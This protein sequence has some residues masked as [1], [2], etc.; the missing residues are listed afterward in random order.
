MEI[1]HWVICFVLDCALHFTQNR[2]FLH[3]N[4][5]STQGTTGSS[6]FCPG[7]AGCA[8]F[9]DGVAKPLRRAVPSARIQA[10]ILFMTDHST[11]NVSTACRRTAI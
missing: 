2:L 4:L 7:I 6:S 3:L 10:Q 9:A 1:P 5:T 11:L 8:I